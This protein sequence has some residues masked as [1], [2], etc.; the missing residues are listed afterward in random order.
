MLGA[1]EFAGVGWLDWLVIFGYLLLIAS[2]GVW[3]AR[4]VKSA[5][6]FFMSDR[7]SGKLLMMFFTFGTGTH[8]DQAVSVAAESYK[9]GASGIWYQWLWLPCTPF[10]WLIAPVFRRMR[11]V[12]T[13]DYF[14]ARYGHSVA[15]L[16]AIMGILQLMVNIGVMLKGSSAMITAVSGGII[17]P[18]VAIWAMTITFVIYGVAGGLNAAI[19]NDLIQGLMTLVLSFLILPFALAA[20]GWID[21]LRETVNNPA[22]FEIVAP[23]KITGFYIFIICLNAL[24]GWATQPHSMSTAAA[25]K[26]EMEGRVGV[27]CGSFFKRTCTIAWAITGLCAVGY[28]LSRQGDVSDVD[29]VYGLMAGE[30]LP[31]IA[32]GLVGLFIAGML[33]SVMSSCDAF[34]VAS[35]ALF[36]ENVYKPFIV[37]NRPDSHYTIVGRIT[38][39]IVV[40]CGIFFAFQLTSVITG[41][42]IFWKI[43]A[44]MGMAFWVG[45]FWR[46][47]TVAAVFVSTFSSFFVFLLTSEIPFL[48]YNPNPW[49]VEHLPAYMMW[50]GAIYLPWQMI[51]Y[52]AVGFVTIVLVSLFTR[53]TD[54]EKLDR[55][56][57]CIRT[58]I[59]KGEPETEPFTLPPGTEPAPRKVLFDHPDFE[60][61]KPDRVTIIGFLGGW[62][63]VA[64]MVLV[65]YAALAL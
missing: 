61:P 53:P 55:L 5:S 44:M 3:A 4:K 17:D 47:A 36:T 12:T 59:K 26:T 57:T 15:V 43:S 51:F 52:L 60:I 20:V 24:I 9:S 38:A 13:G 54:K 2:I 33:A 28:Y 50:D 1:V 35:S 21:G 11:A 16:F 25:G 45:L 40:L 19:I 42:E 8:S 30:L 22:M 7:K 31:K 18:G 41:L 14:Y 48:G 46:R 62:V 6:S 64:L 58:P 10:Y 29:Q 37:K 49:F 27:M 23:G 39:A 34:M 65:F 32:P 63:G 56:Y